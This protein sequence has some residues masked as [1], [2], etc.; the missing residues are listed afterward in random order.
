MLPL[1]RTR[2][3]GSTHITCHYDLHHREMV[4]WELGCVCVF[5]VSDGVGA[6]LSILRPRRDAVFILCARELVDDGTHDSHDMT[7]CP[8]GF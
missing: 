5:V 4:R 8:V 6:C 2:V 1:F 7:E 3:W